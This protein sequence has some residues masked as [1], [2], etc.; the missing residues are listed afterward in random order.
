MIEDLPGV[1]VRST[2]VLEVRFWAI[3]VNGPSGV[4]DLLT[5]S[6]LASIT[7]VQVKVARRLPT[8][9]RKSA[10]ARAETTGPIPYLKASTLLTA[11]LM[12]PS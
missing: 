3:W 12:I 6:V 2:K 10:G 8:T 7:G 11:A 1:A 4:A 5:V 9:A